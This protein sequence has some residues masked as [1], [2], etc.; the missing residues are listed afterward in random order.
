MRQAVTDSTRRTYAAPLLA[1]RHYCTQR[2]LDAEPLAA[3]PEAAGDWLAELALGGRISAATLRT[4]RSALSTAWEEAG[5]RGSNPLQDPF[6]ERL[7]RGASKLLLTRDLAARAARQITLE[8]TPSVIAQFLPFVL[9]ASSVAAT[10]EGSASPSLV[11]AACSWA[12]TC[13]GVFGLLRPNEFLWVGQGQSAA[14]TASAI[15]FR[16]SP[17]HEAEQGLLPRGVAVTAESIPDRFEVAL[18]A[19]KADPLAR[20]G[21][22]VIAARLA[23]EA[24]WRW[25]HARRDA[26]HTPHAPLFVL[27]NGHAL[28]SRV[29]LNQVGAWY[30]R[31]TGATAKLTGRAFRRGGASAMLSSGASIPDIMAAGRWKTPA[32]V[33]VYSSREAKWVHAAA[34]SRALNPAPAA[35][36]EAAAATTQRWSGA[37]PR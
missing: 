23:V 37:S 20:N 13:L 11:P 21:R 2:G 5:G 12:A 36:P 1:Y 3:T 7:V 34:A 22:L 6:V 18:G 27:A 28:A 14:L 24:L 8:L 4:Y 9:E 29:L 17:R 35:A 10:T 26:G 19:T 30:T 33:G 25:M 32:M 15:T 31:L 16:V